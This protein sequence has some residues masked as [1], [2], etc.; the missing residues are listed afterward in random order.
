LCS[1]EDELRRILK[2]GSVPSAVVAF[3]DFDAIRVKHVA[4]SLNLRIPDDLSVVGFDDLWFAELP[5]FRFTTITQP[6]KKIGELA[7]EMAVK[8]IRRE[9]VRPVL[10]EPELVVRESTA[11]ISG[12]S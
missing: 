6:R 10:L 2:G 11:M 1:T 7:A 8:R 9:K 5:E 4:E 3:S 12:R